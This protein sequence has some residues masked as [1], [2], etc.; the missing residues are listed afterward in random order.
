VYNDARQVKITLV[1]IP[2]PGRW[3]AP[4]EKR[5]ALL[6]KSM[7]RAFGWRCVEMKSEE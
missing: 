4:P 3:Q 1:I 5:L 7:L 2:A 6:L